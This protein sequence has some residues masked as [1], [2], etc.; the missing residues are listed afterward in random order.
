[1]LEECFTYQSAQKELLYKHKEFA[2]ACYVTMVTLMP[3]SGV[4][5]SKKKIFRTI[6]NG[7]L[8]VDISGSPVVGARWKVAKK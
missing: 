4:G 5:V 1:M 2:I 8:A 6:A 7:L 3:N